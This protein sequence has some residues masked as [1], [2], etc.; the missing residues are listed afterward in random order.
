LNLQK[1]VPGFT[2]LALILGI[3]T[4]AADVVSQEKLSASSSTPQIWFSSGDDL[5]VKAVAA[6]PDFMHLFDP[7]PSWPAGTA[8][9]NVQLRAPWFLRMPDETVQQVTGFLKQNNIALAVPLGFVSS[10]TC[11]QGVEGL[12][13]ARQQAVYPREMKKR[14]IDLDY[15]V[16]DEPLFFGHDYS[17]KNACN[18]SIQ[19][20]AESVARNVKVIRSYYPKVQ[21]VLVEPEQSL[22]GGV[23][24][25]SQFLDAYQAA[26]N[27]LPVAVRFDLAWGQ[28]DKWHREWHSDI[29]QFLHMLK[30]RGIGYSIIYNAGHVN[31]RVPNTDAAWIASAKANVADWQATIHEK[32]AQVV[33]QTWSPNPIRIVPE[34]DPST[35]TGYLKWFVEH[36]AR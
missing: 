15:V 30:A 17:G 8:R 11:G 33:I 19:Q 9:V 16:M 10:D 28:V 14:G 18:F 1:W 13:T 35:M 31:G 2:I 12:G 3:A 29:P 32:P 34:S 25:L 6:H 26:L 5:E 27:E 4:L 36:A 23:A 22:Q 21:F 24:E 20:V 7:R